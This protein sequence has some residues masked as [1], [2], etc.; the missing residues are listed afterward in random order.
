MKDP[1]MFICGA[2]TAMLFMIDKPIE[3]L[4]NLGIAIAISVLVGE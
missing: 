4:V 3:A 2:T 1:I